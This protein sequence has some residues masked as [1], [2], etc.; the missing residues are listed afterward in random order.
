MIPGALSRSHP[1]ATN[2]VPLRVH[3]AR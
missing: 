1:D 3:D 2:P